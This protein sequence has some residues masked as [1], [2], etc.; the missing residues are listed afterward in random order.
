MKKKVINSNECQVLN[1]GRGHGGCD[2][3]PL[4]T[5]ECVKL[6]SPRWGLEYCLD[7]DPGKDFD[8]RS[9]DD[10][11]REYV[12][13]HVEFLEMKTVA[14]DLFMQGL[15]EHERRMR[16]RRRREGIAW[17]VAIGVC[18]LVFVLALVL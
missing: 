16:L 1:V 9:V 14:Q 8:E 15:I 13:R 4:E 11:I 7:R 17:A 5:D 10:G 18:I 6:S 3:C 12:M 2:V